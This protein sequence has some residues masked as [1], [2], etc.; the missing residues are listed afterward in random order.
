MRPPRPNLSNYEIKRLSGRDGIDLGLEQLRVE[1]SDSVASLL[2]VLRAA[3]LVLLAYLLVLW[4]GWAVGAMV[5]TSVVLLHGGLGRL[6]PIAKLAAKLLGRAEKHLY[7]F[8]QK[9][10][11]FMWFIRL[12]A[13]PDGDLVVFSKEELLDIT[14]RSK[15]VLSAQERR[16]LESSFEFG[17]KT[18]EQIMTPR[19]SIDAIKKDELLGPLTL[20]DLYKT[21]HSRLPVYVD[22][23]DHIV[24]VLHVQ[25]LLVVDRSKSALAGDVMEKKVYYIHQNQT[26]SHAL[27]AFIKTRHHLFVVVNE[28]RETVGVVTLEDVMEQLLGQ[29]IIDEFDNHDDIRQVAARN[30]HGN[31]RPEKHTDV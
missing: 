1:L 7:G 16:R 11:S 9:A 6:Q 12:P 28:F 31:N 15:G 25:D 23:I 8:I 21:G 17:S 24:G 19:S 4:F 18:V 5:A 10:H 14:A 2:F 22:D 3:L 27:N 13:A 26:L 30:P 29:K 20:D